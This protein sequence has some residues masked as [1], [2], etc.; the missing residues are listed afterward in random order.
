MANLAV[1]PMSELLA[2]AWSDPS[3]T[4]NWRTAS[5][6]LNRAGFGGTS[7]EIDEL[8][9]MG[10]QGA[11]ERIVR[12]QAVP[13]DL[14]G[15]DFGTLSHPAFSSFRE[16]RRFLRG[17]TRQQRR[18][19]FQLVTQA[20]FVKMREMR[21]WWLNRMVQSKRPLEEKMT[22][23][24]HGLFVSAFSS[25]H[26]AYHM[27]MQNQLFRRFA[28]G[29]A[30][31]LTLSISKDPAMLRYL[32]NNQNRRGHP[33]ENY[34]RE[35][36]ELFT[37]GIGNY[38]EEDVR[39]SARAWTGWT[40]LGD[41]F[42]FRPFQHDDG[43][44][45]FLGRTGRFDGDD[46]VRII[47][48][49]PAAAS[50]LAFKL[51]AF[52]VSDDPPPQV[53]AAL[54]ATLRAADWKVGPVLEQLFASRWFYSTAVMRRK[55]KTPIELVAGSLRRLEVA[56]P[57]SNRLLQS[58]KIMGQE[59][60]E[61][62]NV[63]GWPHGRAWI[64]TSTLF[65]RY[66]MPAQLLTGHP[67]SPQ[68]QQR[69]EAPHAS[70]GFSPE[71]HLARAGIAT[72]DA[73]VDYFLRLLIQDDIEPAKRRALLCALDGSAVP[74]GKPLNPADS[75]THWRLENLVELIMAMPEYQLC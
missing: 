64:N 63:G 26:N 67:Q 43:Q 2:P 5:H 50:H 8:V 9:R 40:F 42:I 60:F 23:F 71:M 12:Y 75:A 61:A 36:M 34:A 48:E 57:D 56:A 70:T 13:D 58:L 19:Y 11:V 7:A 33:N 35:L 1:S 21:C 59:L 41:R 69:D 28:T 52:F 45:T 30:K 10:P 14:P 53:V 4:W 72:T 39:Q 18:A 25:V 20:G 16:T 44:K 29:S 24:W 6:L 17:M 68:T 31:V 22:L 62:P 47:Y 15:L 65:A 73:A 37:L 27:Y 66:D 32:N 74:A 3:F 49:Q 55:I 54:A 46:I 51:A 38:S